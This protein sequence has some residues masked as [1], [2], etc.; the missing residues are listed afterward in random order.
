VAHCDIVMVAP[1]QRVEMPA[2]NHSSKMHTAL[3]FSTRFTPDA[4][5]SI[6]TSSELRYTVN[7]P[8]V[9]MPSLYLAST[10]A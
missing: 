6:V 4:F 9:K 10:R 1:Q 3:Q 2:L 8:E 5:H 7:G